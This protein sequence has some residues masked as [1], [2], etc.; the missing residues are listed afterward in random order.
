MRLHKALGKGLGT[1]LGMGLGKGLGM[2]ATAAVLMTSVGCSSNSDR[3][4]AAL[5]E[6]RTLREQLSEL[7]RQLSQCE[8]D[9]QTLNA[10]N[11]ALSQ[12][13]SAAQATPVATN[14]PSGFENIRDAQVSSRNGE[15]VVSVAGD[16]LFTSGKAELRDSAK[17]TLDQI[18]RVLQDQYRGNSIRV[19]GYT[20]ADPIRRSK[21]ESNEHL[22]AARALSVEKYLV[23]RGVNKDA[24]YAAAFGDADQR[25]TKSQSR[26]VEIVVLSS[27]G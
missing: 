10:D 14:T 12:Q 7:D 20:D 5:A 17:R 4:Q 25:S 22:S 6:N 1:S 9:N 15:I 3:Y 27:A 18:A 19:E 13:V 21:W 8:Q 11:I 2:V 16:V 24:I 23:G 26:R